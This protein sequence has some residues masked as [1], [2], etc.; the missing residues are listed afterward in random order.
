MI[1]VSGVSDLETDEKRPPEDQRIEVFCN[2]VAAAALI[3]RDTLLAERLVIE[4]GAEFTAWTDDEVRELARQFNVSR[5]TVLRRLLTFGRTTDALYKQKRAQYIS[6]YLANRARQKV[7]AEGAEIK[8]NMPQETVSNFCRPFV[9]MLLDNYF[10]DR[11]TLSEASGYLGLKVKH[12]PKLAK[13]VGI[14]ERPWQ[15]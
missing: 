5:E 9:R 8:R 15:R 13:A 2:H 3:P 6:E 4:R 10:Q 14:R 7:L 12:F 1:H 11:M